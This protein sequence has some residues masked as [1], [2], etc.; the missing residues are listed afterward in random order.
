MEKTQEGKK[1]EERSAEK[2]KRKEGHKMKEAKEDNHVN[3]RGIK[4]EDGGIGE[5]EGNEEGDR[6]TQRIKVSLYV[7]CISCSV[8]KNVTSQT[9]APF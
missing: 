3:I 9:L 2:C 5:K 4:R 8:Q 7:L 6:D 1:R